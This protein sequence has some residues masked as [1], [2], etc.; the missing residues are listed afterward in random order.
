MKVPAAVPGWDAAEWCGCAAVD[1]LTLP[2]AASVPSLPVP[3]VTMV[4][5]VTDIYTYKRIILPKVVM[6]LFF[7][8]TT[9]F[10]IDFL[11]ILAIHHNSKD[12]WSEEMNP[13]TRK[14]KS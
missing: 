1:T 14:V 7:A 9:D 11:K 3:T 4:V 8:E 13:T 10:S 12:K 6:V 5:P 2:A